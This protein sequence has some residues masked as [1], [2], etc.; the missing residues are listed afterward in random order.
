M[1][2]LL[3]PY[4]TALAVLGVIATLT[5]SSSPPMAEEG[6]PG[7]G[8]TLRAP[9]SFAGIS[10]PRERAIDLFLEMSKVILHPRCLNR[11]P[12][13]GGPTQ[14]DEMHPHVPPV[15]RGDADFGATGMTC[16]TCHGSENFPPEATGRSRATSLGNSRRCPWAGEAFRSGTSAGG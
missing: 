4:P 9:E 7:G 10:D 8:E 14:G 12:V 3:F 15:A 16:D 5:L 13:T 2:L 6:V 11:H 1:R